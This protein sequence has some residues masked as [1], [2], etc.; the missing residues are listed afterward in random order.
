MR[1]LRFFAPA[2]LALALSAGAACNTTV[3]EPV[4]GSGG[5]GQS[6]S[7]GSGGGGAGA[8]TSTSV[9][10]DNPDP[11][12]GCVGWEEET[13]CQCDCGG[14]M[15][16]TWQHYVADC[17]SVPTASACPNGF[18]GAGGAPPQLSCTLLEKKKICGP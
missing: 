14:T 13:K 7:T 11:D 6:T 9:G 18:E 2:L 8:T 5:G 17:Q 1:F 4:G 3:E 10:C 12:C 16:D 15:V